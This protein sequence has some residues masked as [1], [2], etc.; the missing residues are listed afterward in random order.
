MSDLEKYMKMTG[1]TLPEVLTGQA[2]IG[3]QKL[4]ELISKCV[5]EKKKI[6]WKDGDIESGEI[7][8]MS[9]SLEDL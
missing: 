6:V 5:K 7:Y 1:Q 8:T 9:Y 2:A 3:A 4:D